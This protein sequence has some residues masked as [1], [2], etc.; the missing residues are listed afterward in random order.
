M[1]E[2]EKGK[3][4]PPPPQEIHKLV[5]MDFKIYSLERNPRQ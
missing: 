1:D 4:T 2:C 5:P 3:Q